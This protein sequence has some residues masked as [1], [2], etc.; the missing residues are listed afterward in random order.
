MPRVK[1]WQP[2]VVVVAVAWNEFG[3]R[4]GE[5]H[6]RAVYSDAFVLVALRLLDAGVR[7]RAV[8]AALGM[9]VATLA[10]VARGR[11]RCQVAERWGRA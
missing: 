1:A 9:P 2:E 4:I 10:S 6:P 8:A 3:R 7:R 5:G 11:T